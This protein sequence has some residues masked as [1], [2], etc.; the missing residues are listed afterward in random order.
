MSH[1][2]SYLCYSVGET[3]RSSFALSGRATFKFTIRANRD[4]IS[5]N[6]CF[7]IWRMHISGKKRSAY[8]YGCRKIHFVCMFTMA[9]L[10]DHLGSDPFSKVIYDKWSKYFLG[11]AFR[12]FWM[13]V[14]HPHSVLK[15]SEGSFNPPAKS[16]KL[17]QFFRGILFLRKI[18]DKRFRK[19]LGYADPYDPVLFRSV[20]QVLADSQNSHCREQICNDSDPQTVF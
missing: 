19:F 11:Y 5:C 3:G 12:F 16:V 8:M 6:Q 4:N 14:K 10:N 13:K 18:G 2:T 17:F 15:A 20:R 1:F 9:F 7:N